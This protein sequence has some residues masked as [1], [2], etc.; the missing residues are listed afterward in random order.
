MITYVSVRKF[1]YIFIKYE[2]MLLNPLFFFFFFLTI[3]DGRIMWSS[4]GA[5]D[6]LSPSFNFESSG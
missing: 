6:L 5:G 1:H 2:I 3:M 4:G